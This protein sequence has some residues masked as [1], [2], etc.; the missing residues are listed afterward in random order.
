MLSKDDFEREYCL[1]APTRSL[2]QWL[3]P[4]PNR[5][6]CDRVGAARTSAALSDHRRHRYRLGRSDQNN[7]PH[8]YLDQ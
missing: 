1:Y 7:R 6:R 5:Q 2:G 4:I 3:I 8:R